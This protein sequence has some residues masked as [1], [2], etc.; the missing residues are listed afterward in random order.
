MKSTYKTKAREEIAAY[1]KEHA[2]Q[3]FTAREIYEAVCVPGILRVNYDEVIQ[4]KIPVCRVIELKEADAPDN[5]IM[6]LT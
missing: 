1:L 5:E 6:T 2:E 4:R 3:R